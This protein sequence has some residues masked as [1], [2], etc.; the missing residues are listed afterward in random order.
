MFQTK[1][2]TKTTATMTNEVEI[3]ATLDHVLRESKK[4][5]QIKDGRPHWVDIPDYYE[6]YRAAVKQRDR[7]AT[8][9]DVDLYPEPLFAK[10]A[11]NENEEESEYIR[12][13]YRNY[14]HPVFVDYLS[15]IGKGLN[16]GNWSL[17][18]TKGPD[19]FAEYVEGSLEYHK[20]VEAYVKDIILAMKAKDPNGV[21]AIDVP[22]LKM[23]EVN[24][25]MVPDDREPWRPQPIY[26]SCAQIVAWEQNEYAMLESHQKSLVEYGNSVVKAGRVFYVYDDT[27][28]WKVEQYGKFID[29][30]FNIGVIFTHDLGYIPVQKLKGVPSVLP[31]GR[32][33]YT[34]KFYYAVDILDNVLLN[35]NYMQC[36]V[37]NCMFPF[38]VMVGDPCDFMDGDGNA[39]NG[40][41]VLGEHGERHICRQCNGSGLKVRVSPMGTYLLRAAEGQAQGD[42]VYSKPV[43]YIS[44]SADPLKFVKELV[45]TDTEQAR[46]MLHIHTSNSDVKGNQDMTATGMAIDLKAQYAFI[47]PESDQVFDL[48]HFLLRTIADIR[49]PSDEIEFDLM[50]PRTFDFR[51]DADMLADIETARKAGAPDAVIHSLI[52]QFLSNRFYTDSESMAVFDVIVAADRLLTLN[53]DAIVQRKAQNLVQPWEVILHDSAVSIINELIATDPTFLERSI[54]EKVAALVAAAKAKAPAETSRAAAINNILGVA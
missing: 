28:I 30:T 8:H 29:N 31:D 37:S 52:Y 38:R 45:D 19:G 18:I 49:Y 7:I 40:G 16:D 47:M 48:F 46:T 6:G 33:Y 53:S 25:Q 51:T 36:S 20:S 15:V 44:P 1:T 26:Y 27:F 14:T 10:R 11:P 12:A 34:S 5:Y 17:K 41:F 24:G 39:C 3:K 23:V 54:D 4:S 35:R 22:P 13:N 43:E 32:I 50:Y 42:A 21:I 9:A 2:A